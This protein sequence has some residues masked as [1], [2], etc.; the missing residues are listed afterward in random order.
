MLSRSECPNQDIQLYTTTSTFGSFNAVRGI[1]HGCADEQRR[2]SAHMPNSRI[3]FY[4]SVSF[5]VRETATSVLFRGNCV[6][7]RLCH[8]GPGPR[9]GTGSPGGTQTL[10]TVS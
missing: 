5:S 4:I 2:K 1:G 9:V 10:L 8:Q 6:N 7:Q 3:L